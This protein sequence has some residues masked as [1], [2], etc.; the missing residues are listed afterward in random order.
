MTI[1]WN[2]RNANENETT[3]AYN[4]MPCQTCNSLPEVTH[5]SSVDP[6]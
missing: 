6:P 5:G 3:S 2:D 1:L 4:I